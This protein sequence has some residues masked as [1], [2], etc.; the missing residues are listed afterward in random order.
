MKVESLDRVPAMLAGISSGA[1][2]PLHSVVTWAALSEAS[3]AAH[4]GNEDHTE[5]FCQDLID[6]MADAET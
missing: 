1:G 4:A 6:E 3:A 5:D 2:H